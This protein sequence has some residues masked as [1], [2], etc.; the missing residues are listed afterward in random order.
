MVEAILNGSK[1]QTRRIIKPKPDEDGLAFNKNKNE[2]QDTGD[3]TYN[4]KAQPGDIFWVRET[5]A[6]A[7]N[8]ASSEIPN[9]MVIAYRTE[10]AYFYQGGEKLE[11]DNW[12]WDKIKWKPSI[13]MPKDVC[14]IFLECTNVRV[15]KLHHISEEDSISEGIQKI[16]ASNQPD[17]VI[18]YHDYMVKPKDG[19]NTFFDPILSFYS[20]WQS[21]NGKE[22]LDSN[23]W[24]WVYDF[25][26]IEKP[27]DFK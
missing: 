5:W 15:E 16:V 6:E 4:P 11:T 17:R 23:P 2:W 12:N 3:K 20:L 10:D 18:G 24:L 21:I 9:S 8:F 25:K 19:F 27:D 7:G 26:V 13:F 1:T 22:S 14:R